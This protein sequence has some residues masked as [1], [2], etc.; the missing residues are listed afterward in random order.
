MTSR[1]TLFAEIEPDAGRYVVQHVDPQSGSKS[2]I[3]GPPSHGT[4]YDRE[5]AVTFTLNEAAEALAIASEKW[6]HP[7][8]Q[9]SIEEA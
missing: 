5:Q 7:E 4:S 6:P 2:W 9:W 8:H 1:P 3:N